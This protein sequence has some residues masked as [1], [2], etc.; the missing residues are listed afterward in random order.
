[1][2]D[3]RRLAGLDARGV[4]Y[5]VEVGSLDR[6][7]EAVR[8]AYAGVTYCPRHRPPFDPR[9]SRVYRADPPRPD[10]FHC[11]CPTTS[12]ARLGARASFQPARGTGHH[13]GLR[14]GAFH[15]EVDL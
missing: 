11:D 12:R 7:I 6:Y 8:S 15:P 1:M 13:P 10:G 5:L 2:T 3:L 14:A 9:S 4:A